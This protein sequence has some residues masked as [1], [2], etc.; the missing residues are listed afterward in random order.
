MRPLVC[1]TSPRHSSP[2]N[3]RNKGLSCSSKQT[4]I[5]LKFFHV[6]CSS[7]PS[8]HYHFILPVRF[9]LKDTYINCTRNS[10]HI[11]TAGCQP[12]L[13]AL[14]LAQQDNMF[15]QAD[16]IHILAS[17]GQNLIQ[18]TTHCCPTAS[19]VCATCTFTEPKNSL[20]QNA[21]VRYH[22]LLK[23]CM[24]NFTRQY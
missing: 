4:D 15:Q 6:L 7:N 19:T 21:H 8:S 5:S 18:F 17:C 9:L 3:K 1:D 11:C 14:R 22:D 16:C 20:P 12:L 13:R 10:V 24:H 2:C 23:H